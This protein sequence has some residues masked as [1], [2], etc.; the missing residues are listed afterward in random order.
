MTTFTCDTCAFTTDRKLNYMRHCNTDKHKLKVSPAVA[1]VVNNAMT[2]LASLKM[3]EMQTK[4]EFKMKE[5]ELKNE[6][7][8]KESLLKEKLKQDIKQEIVEMKQ[9]A[10]DESGSI[11]YKSIETACWIRDFKQNVWERFTIEEYDDIFNTFAT[12]EDVFIKHFMA[13]YDNN[14]SYVIDPRCNGN[15]KYYIYEKCVDY[16]FHSNTYTP[17][18]IRFDI[19]NILSLVPKVHKAFGELAKDEGRNAKD[20]KLQDDEKKRIE[21]LM[22]D[23]MTKIVIY[24]N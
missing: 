2:E 13:E 11:N 18:T 19:G 6:I 23:M 22:I 7:K 4:N 20:W 24:D 17:E 1:T 21:D 8:M 15:K 5:L 10:V 12:F 14:K 9:Q 16:V 3:T